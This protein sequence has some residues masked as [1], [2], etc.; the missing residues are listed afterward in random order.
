MKYWSHTAKRV[1][2]TLNMPKDEKYG[3]LIDI[4]DNKA[5][6]ID[7]CICMSDLKIRVLSS[8]IPVGL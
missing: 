1:G 5:C 8:F 7:I 3:D 2:K 4:Y 6:Y